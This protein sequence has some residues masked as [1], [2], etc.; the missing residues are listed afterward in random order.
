MEVDGGFPVGAPYTMNSYD[1]NQQNSQGQSRSWTA[2]G[3]SAAVESKLSG[4]PEVTTTACFNCG[5]PTHWRRDCPVCGNDR[6]R[7]TSQQ[8]Q[9]VVISNLEQ[10]AE[11]FVRTEIF[12]RNVMAILDT[13]CEMSIIIS[14]LMG[15]TPLEETNLK[16]YAANGTDIPLLETVKIPIVI[17]G[18]STMAKVVVS[19]VVDELILGVDWLTTQGCV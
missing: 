13:G 2:T 3:R 19:D 8:S 6:R 12:E 5:D 15:S 7:P 11:I 14:I 18:Y 17:E 1:S 9:V 10:T 16:L 4:Q